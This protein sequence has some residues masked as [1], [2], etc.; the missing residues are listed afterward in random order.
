M[1]RGGL[2][3]LPSFRPSGQAPH[4]PHSHPHAGT[5]SLGASHVCQRSRARVLGQHVRRCAGGWRGRLRRATAARTPIAAPEAPRPL[6][7]AA[8]A[9]AAGADCG[10]R[11]WAA[12]AAPHSSTASRSAL[13]ALCGERARLLQPG[14]SQPSRDAGDSACLALS[15]HFSQISASC[16][17]WHSRCPK[18]QCDVGEASDVPSLLPL[19]DASVPQPRSH[20]RDCRADP[21]SGAWHGAWRVCVLE[22]WKRARVPGFAAELLPPRRPLPLPRTMP[23]RPSPAPQPPAS[24]P[25]RRSCCLRR[26][27]AP[28][29]AYVARP[30]RVCR[31]RAPHRKRQLA[32]I[33]IRLLPSRQRPA[34]PTGRGACCRFGIACERPSSRGEELRRELTSQ[35]QRQPHSSPLLENAAP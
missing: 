32:A 29:A 35:P 21:A 3:A 31:S 16:T 5:L 4:T 8:A 26:D 7:D 2:G 23:P 34:R 27:H 25:R 15:S 30:A 6:L 13:R 22:T 9:P 20:R 28:A 17:A 24:V 1:P 14:R 19:E 11:E 12:P 10:R 18:W 33:S